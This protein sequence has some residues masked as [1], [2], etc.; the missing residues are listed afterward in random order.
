MSDLK[1]AIGY[2]ETGNW[3]AAHLI[4]QEDES[5]EGCWA[6][7]IVHLLEGDR[8]NAGYWYRRAGRDL[9]AGSAGTE[10]AVAE[11]IAALKARL[12]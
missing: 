6:H 5:F 4:V 11:E 3:E 1:T 9:P 12:G 2:L 7:G 8:S 10:E